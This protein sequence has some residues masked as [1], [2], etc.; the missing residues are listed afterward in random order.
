[1]EK[2]LK[3]EELEKLQSAIKVLNNIQLQIGGLEAQ[4]HEL[5]HNM[6]TAKLNLS[7]LQK[8]LEEIYGDIS[9]DV[10]TGEIKNNE[11]STQD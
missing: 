5:L 6:E 10:S 9:V 2:Q 7:S 4:K 8:E 1:M 11:P 3:A